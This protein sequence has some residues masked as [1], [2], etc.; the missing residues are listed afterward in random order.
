MDFFRLAEVNL[1]LESGPLACS[2]AD[3]EYYLRLHCLNL[4]VVITT[5][6]LDPNVKSHMI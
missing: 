4:G 2:L 5:V 1:G 6:F 3:Q